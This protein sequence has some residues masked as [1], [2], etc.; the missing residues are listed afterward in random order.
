M[1]LADVLVLSCTVSGMMMLAA[2]GL[3]TGMEQC[4]MPLPATHRSL[5]IASS[6]SM[7]LIHLAGACTAESS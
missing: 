2:S 4:I 1:A 3:G 7:Q 6:T 5:R